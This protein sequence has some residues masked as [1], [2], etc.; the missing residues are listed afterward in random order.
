MVNAIGLILGPASG[1]FFSGFKEHLGVFY[2]EG[3]FHNLPLGVII[4]VREGPGIVDVHNNL[5][6]SRLW[7]DAFIY[8]IAI[9]CGGRWWLLWSW[10]LKLLAV[11]QRARRV[12]PRRKL[13]V[14]H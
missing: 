2:C 11:Y 12:E 5:N 6:A 14:Q 4:S 7:R 13:S 9:V 3:E 8:L 1:C 10:A